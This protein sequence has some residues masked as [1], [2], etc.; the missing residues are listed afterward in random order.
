MSLADLFL[1]TFGRN[2]PFRQNALSW[3]ASFQNY[4]IINAFTS[5]GCGAFILP[6]WFYPTCVVFISNLT[7]SFFLN[8][9]FICLLWHF[10]FLFFLLQIPNYYCLSGNYAIP[11]IFKSIFQVMKCEYQTIYFHQ[12]LCPK[13]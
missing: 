4:A 2:R 11:M 13:L 12:Y 5:L 9:P 1:M 6:S 8:S 7:I 10:S 3:T